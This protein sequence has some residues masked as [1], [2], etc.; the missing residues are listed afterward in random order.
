MNKPVVWTIAGSDSSAGAGAQADLKTMESFGVHGC[1]IITAVTAQSVK[2]V[3]AVEPVSV[4]M[5]DAQWDALRAHPPAAI[6]IGMLRGAEQLQ[7]LAARLQEYPDVPVVCDPVLHASDGSALQDASVRDIFMR[8]LLPRVSVLTPNIPEAHWLLG[9]AVSATASVDELA[10]AL[11]QAG[12]QA[13]LLKGG[14]AKDQRARDYF[15]TVSDAFWMVHARLPGVIHGSGCIV[16]SA[17][18]A[19]M[20]LGYATDDAAVLARRYLNQ[21]WRLAADG[22]AAEGFFV[23]AG[24]PCEPVDIPAVNATGNTVRRAFPSLGVQPIGLYP[25]VDSAAWIRRLL[26]LGV[27]T[28]QLRIK[29]QS[30]EFIAREVAESVAL[31]RQYG[32]RVFIND[33]WQAAIEAGAYGVHLGQEDIEQADLDA[34]ASAGLRLGLSNHSEREIARAHALAPSYMALGPIYET[35]T[36]VMR[37][38]PQGLA[39]LNDWV[40]LLGKAYPLVAIGGIDRSRMQA[41][42]ATGVAN[43][44]VVRA[45]TEAADPSAAVRELQQMLAVIGRQ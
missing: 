13:V 21:G 34:M 1:A 42:L 44:A 36:K 4:G 20:A 14:H 45:I 27:S 39:R 23:H 41:V 16:A 19:A 9:A 11:Q 6:K 35:T 17:M 7:W 40:R 22:G 18:A 29:Q 24:W 5:L 31:G 38:A 3:H 25:V 43:V 15:G 30:P 26:P 37:F 12:A 8:E 10:R 33:H 28:I 2:T 32:A